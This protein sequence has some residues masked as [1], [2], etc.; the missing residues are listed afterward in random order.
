MDMR[1][2]LQIPKHVLSSMKFKWG[3]NSIFP[4]I[5]L[6]GAGLLELHSDSIWLVSTI[7]PSFL[8]PRILWENLAHEFKFIRPEK[9]GQVFQQALLESAEA[10]KRALGAVPGKSGAHLVFVNS[11]VALESR[12]RVASKSVIDLDDYNKWVSDIGGDSSEKMSE[13]EYFKDIIETIREV[14]LQTYPLWASLIALLPPGPVK[15]EAENR[16]REGCASVGLDTNDVIAD[17]VP[18]AEGS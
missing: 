12:L 16:F 9:R 15:A 2:I 17:W 6:T 11:I 14:R 5:E 18:L 4:S 1:N 7:G 3:G 8:Q 13:S 10:L